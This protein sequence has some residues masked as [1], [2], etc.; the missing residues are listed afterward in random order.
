MIK[1]PFSYAPSVC[2]GAVTFSRKKL[3][4]RIFCQPR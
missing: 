1:T 4:P 3:L 2:L